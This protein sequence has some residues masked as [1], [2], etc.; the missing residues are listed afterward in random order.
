MQKQ[1]YLLRSP[2]DRKIYYIGSSVSSYTRDH[3]NGKIVAW[4]A[5][6]LPLLP[7]LEIIEQT[8]DWSVRELFW[9][10]H[11]IRAGEPLLN[12]VGTPTATSSYKKA[13]EGRKRTWSWTPEQRAA[14]SQKQQEMWNKATPEE[15][16]ARTR[17][18][19]R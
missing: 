13:W 6:L 10:D 15:R 5:T 18:D 19:R 9:I 14:F 7:I 12:V 2:K 16:A 11:Y 17:F 1:V 4:A 8:T 3:D